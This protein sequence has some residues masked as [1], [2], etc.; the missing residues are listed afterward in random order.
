MSPADDRLARWIATLEAKHLAELTFPEVSRA[1]RALSST[2]VERRQKL[3]EGAALSGNGKRA[4]F[5]LFYGP[6]HHL[7]LTHIV[8][9]LPEATAGVRTLLDL[10]CGTGASGAAWANACPTAPRLIG[11]DRHPWAIGEAAATYRAFR[12]PATVRQG[13]IANAALPKGPASILAAFTM[14]ELGDSER[15]ML[16]TRLVER[17]RQGDRVLIVEPLAGFVARW[18]NRWRDTVEAAGGRADEWR[19]RPELPPIVAKLDRAAGLNHR[20]ITGRSL[21]L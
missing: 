5:A 1:L 4:A 16:L 3:A 20:E 17:A 14:N 12:I 9:R 10:G 15:D 7:L 21:W 11:I 8:E 18:W 2:Y 19:L 6:L 13:D